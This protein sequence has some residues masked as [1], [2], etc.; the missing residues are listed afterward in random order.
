MKKR[1]ALAQPVDLLLD[2]KVVGTLR[3]LDVDWH[4]EEELLELIAPA[5]VSSDSDPVPR[6]WDHYVEVMTPRDAGLGP[7][8]RKLINAALKVATVDECCRAI[9]GCFASD[10]HMKRGRYAGRS[11]AKHSQLSKIL[12]GKRGGRTRR[13][14]IDFFLEIAERSGLQSGVTS[15]DPARIDSAKR[16]VLDAWSFPG[17]EQAQE[18]G[19]AARQWLQELGWQ[20]EADEDGMPPGR[21]MFRPPG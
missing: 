9:D 11:G 14:Q 6:V 1:L 2:G 8:E 15:A 19:E 16:D 13:E 12:K 10:F 21:P 17:N 4:T 7:D 20:I 18:Q 5:A 3:G